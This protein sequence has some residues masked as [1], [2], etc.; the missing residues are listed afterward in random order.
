MELEKDYEIVDGRVKV[1]LSQFGRVVGVLPQTVR[2]RIKR[3]VLKKDPDGKLDLE[4]SID[5]W[6]KYRHANLVR[7][8]KQKNVSH[9]E[10]KETLSKILSENN[11]ILEKSSKPE[12]E[13]KKEYEYAKMILLEAFKKN[14]KLK[15]RFILQALR[16]PV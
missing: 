15:V 4:Y 1:N 9:A 8:N 10:A 16:L 5:R 14:H 12:T 11:L 3:K 13:T 6:Y 2:A 7:D